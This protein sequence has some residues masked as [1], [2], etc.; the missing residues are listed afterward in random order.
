MSVTIITFV[1]VDKLGISSSPA[2]DS[3]SYML[4][5]VPIGSIV[6][7]SETDCVEPSSSMGSPS[8]DDVVDV[9]DVVSIFD[10]DFE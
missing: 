6:L 10:V 4:V 8:V 1:S 9:V 7:T 2:L 5:V 3:I